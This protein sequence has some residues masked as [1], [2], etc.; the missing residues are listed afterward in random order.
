ML[1]HNVNESNIWKVSYQGFA[2][3]NSYF[4]H[5]IIFAKNYLFIPEFW[6]LKK[7]IQ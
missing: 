4:F 6:F 5:R 7:K 3:I 1:S 2:A